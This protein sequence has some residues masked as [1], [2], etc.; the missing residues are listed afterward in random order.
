M[1]GDDLLV[2]PVLIPGVES[3]E[4]Y[5]PGPETWVHLWSDEV[6]E[7]PLIYEVSSPLGKP[8][9]FYRESSEWKDLFVNIK[10]TFNF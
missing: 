4:V 5:L 7:G 1:Y 2:A 6:L 3:W 9:V 10:D 8:P